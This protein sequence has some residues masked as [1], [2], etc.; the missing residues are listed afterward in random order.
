[1]EKKEI[2]RLLIDGLL[3]MN[4]PKEHVTVIALMLKSEDQMWTMLDWI[5]KHHKE[6]PSK[7]R[8]LQVAMNI[9]EE[10]K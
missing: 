1:M 3:E 8:V 9:E 2:Q 7:Q 6:N 4:L 10:V 5:I